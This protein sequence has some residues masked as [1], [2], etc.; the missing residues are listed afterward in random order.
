[1]EYLC[2]LSNECL[3]V[4]RVV[5]AFGGPAVPLRPFPFLFSLQQCPAALGPRTCTWMYLATSPL[6]CRLAWVL[7]VLTDTATIFLSYSGNT[8]YLH[9][10]TMGT[11]TIHSLTLDDA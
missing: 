1:M 11:R 6:M 7:R 10:Y 8:Y 2:P 5:I 3:S 4:G 9:V